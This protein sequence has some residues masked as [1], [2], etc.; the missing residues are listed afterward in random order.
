MIAIDTKIS[1]F[2]NQEIAANLNWITMW[3]Q[4]APPAG[5]RDFFLE[6]LEQNLIING[7]TWIGK[8]NYDY[9]FDH[10]G[11]VR[12]YA[13]DADKAQT[14][15]DK[16]EASHKQFW[17]DNLFHFSIESAPVDMALLLEDVQRRPTSSPHPG[18]IV[19][20]ILTVDQIMCWFNNFPNYQLLSYADK[21][22]IDPEILTY[23]WIPLYTETLFQHVEQNLSKLWTV[24]DLPVEYI[25]YAD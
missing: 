24:D 1:A 15:I 17:T 21:Q 20:P 3:E 10:Y 8:Q 22:T 25:Q 11:T 2:Q 9:T 18:D 5:V 23:E 19:F 12:Y 13:W 7:F 6:C 14:F 16:L 4:S